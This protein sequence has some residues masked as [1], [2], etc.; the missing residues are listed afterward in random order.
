MLRVAPYYAAILALGYVFL[1][2]QVIRARRTAKVS[3]GT[4]GKPEVMRASRVHGNFAEYVPFALLLLAM[5]E[6]RGAPA[7]TLHALGVALVVGRTSHAFGVSRTPENFQ[8]RIAG[9]MTTF[10]VLILSALAIFLT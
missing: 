2:L 1:A 7:W 5:L 4:G 6:L 3:L 9:M 10:G 8:Y